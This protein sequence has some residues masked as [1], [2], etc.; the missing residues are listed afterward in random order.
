MRAPLT[1]GLILLLIVPGASDQVDVKTTELQQRVCGGLWNAVNEH[2]VYAD[3]RGHDWKAIG[4]K[5]Q[6]R[7]KGGM[8]YD[9]FY[10]AMQAMLGELGD[11]HSYFQS[12]SQIKAEQAARASQYNFVGIGALM[13]PI[14]DTDQA[15][16]MTVFRDSPAAQAGLRSHDI[17]L[18][19][20][21]GP[22]REKDGRSR[23][24][25]P[26][27]S[28]VVLTV[29]RPG[30]PPRDVTLTRRRV[31]GK[32]P[33]DYRLIPQTSIG[34][35]FLPTLLDET[36][37]DQTREALKELTEDGP[38]DGLVLDNR[39]NGGGLG[40]TAESIMGFFAGGLQGYFVSRARREPLQL[41]PEDVGGSQTV[42][43][44][45]LVD[46]DTVSFGEIV[47]G[48][49]RV[50]GRARIVGGPTLGNVERLRPYDFEDGSRAWIAS[51]TFEPRGL[52]NGIWEETGIIPDVNV[53]S[54]WHEI[55]EAND[56]A[57]AKAVELLIG[58]KN[59]APSIVF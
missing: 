35:I 1:I 48:V 45:V 43:L 23:T 47:S 4:A 53:P 56:P 57:L 14:K 5:Y 2:Y 9:E 29:R 49:L 21:G 10:A 20:D 12:P 42:P 24:M 3:F 30:G 17:I 26:D 28:I 50:A 52:A 8:N 54:R 39:M 18:K 41:K 7:I 38:L 44:V 37:A 36:V 40:K 46:A 51:E 11:G 25:G 13:I 16:I 6:A 34:Y 19:V 27:G 58:Q 15:A 32:L 22:V 59:K 33:I 31:T 55:T